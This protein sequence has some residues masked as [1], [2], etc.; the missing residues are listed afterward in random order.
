V[1]WVVPAAGEAPS[2][3]ELRSF[4]AQSLPDYMLPSALVE[5]ESL[6]LTP[7]GKVD[8]KALPKPDF[9]PLTST[10]QVAARD[11]VESKLVKIWQGVL[12]TPT[13][14]VTDNFFDLGGHSLMA[15][16]LLDEIRKSTGVEIPLTALFQGATVEHLAGIV[17]GT[18]AVQQ[19]I[20]QQIQAGEDRPPF[21]AAVLAGVNALGYVPLAKRLGPEQPFYTLQ[22]PGP[23][24]HATRRP[25]SQHE[26]EQVASDYIRAMRAIQPEGPY[27]LGGTCEGARIA[28]EMTRILESQGESVALLAVIDTWVLENTQN[29]RLWK[30]YYYSER[31]RQLLRQS[32]K[33]QLA[34]VFR[35]VRNRIL[36]RLKAKSAPPKSEWMDTYWPGEDF[37]PSRVQSK[38]T[39]F[40]IPKQPFYYHADEFLGWGSRTNSG[41]DIE[42]IAHGRHRL[43]LREP[44][45]RELAEALS[46]VLKG[47][48]PPELASPT[49]DRE[50]ADAATVSR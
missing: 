5:M 40:K 10:S 36:W 42:I 9:Q 2:L 26:Y 21:F 45:V 31:V 7:N 24:P 15:V 19:T 16:R 6:P 17:R 11:E 49:P 43:L 33:A 44:Y 23:G 3:S 35:A 50:S 34:V 39:V 1:A 28:F 13:V 20:V 22:T 41:V 12:Q 46:K 48:H 32:W 38:I 18:T 4:L 30:I 8:R 25:Y 47:L 37:V 14:G 29:P 27:Y